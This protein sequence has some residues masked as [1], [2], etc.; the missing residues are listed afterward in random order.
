VISREQLAAI[1][2]RNRREATPAELARAEALG[3]VREARCNRCGDAQIVLVK[4]YPDKPGVAVACEC[5]PLDL[6]AQ[7]AGIPERFKDA[8]FSNYVPMDG[9]EDA[10]AK[11]MRWDGETSKVL[12]GAPGRGKTHLLSAMGMRE[13]A[14]GKQVQFIEITR[15]LDGLKARFGT[16]QVQPYFE[17]IA[18]VQ[19][20]LVDDLGAEQDTEWADAQ[21]RALINHRY[22]RRLPTVITTNMGYSETKKRLGEAVASRMTEWEWI[23]VGGIDVRPTLAVRS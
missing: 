20:L 11:A 5:V 7:W 19:T 13:I 14:R 18:N 6:R 23:E 10:L 8:A 12:A 3:D 17:K 16:D 22:S 4:A 15:F 2:E 9:K 21:L 1:Q